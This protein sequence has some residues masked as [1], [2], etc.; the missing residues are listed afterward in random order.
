M[1]ENRYWLD[2]CRATEQKQRK[3]SDTT[4]LL[5]FEYYVF[6]SSTQSGFVD[7]LCFV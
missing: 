3:C 7:A 6:P 2:I 1:S 4:F 5:N